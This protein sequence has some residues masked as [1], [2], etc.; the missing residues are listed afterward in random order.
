MLQA[1]LLRYLAVAHFGRGRGEWERAETP[2]HWTAVVEAALA[3]EAE[4]FDA[5]WQQRGDDAQVL[6]SRLQPL[7]DRTLRA[8]LL[9]L[10]PQSPVP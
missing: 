1:A 9:R 8:V 3:A 10:Y 4:A 7:L 2:P 5:L 6:A